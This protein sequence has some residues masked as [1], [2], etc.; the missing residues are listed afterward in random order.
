M[1]KIST[2]VMFWAAALLA[3]CGGGSS[4]DAFRPGAPAGAAP[5]ASVA[6]V[7]VT[8]NKVSILSDGSESATITAF[9]RDSGNALINGA[10]VTFGASSG[11]ISP[12]SATT[13]VDG[14]ATATLVT[15]GDQ[16]LR[17]ITV[18][19]TSGGISS[20]VAVPVVAAQPPVA[21]G[22]LTLSTSTPTIPSDGSNPATITAVVQDTSNRFLANVPVVFTTS[23]GGLAIAQSSTNTSGAATATLSTASD[24]T[25]RPITVTAVAGG[26]TRTVVVSVVGSRL[27][28]QGPA[29]LVLGAS[30][31]YT[32][33]LVDS[34]DR[35][36]AGR[37]ITATSAR[38]NTLSAPSLTTDATGR[39]TV[40]VTV[41]NAGN[42]TLTLTGLGL[43]TTQPIAV[44]SD[45]F[46]FTTPAEAAEIPLSTPQTVTIRW[47]TAGN[48]VAVGT[49]V[50]F[51]S[52]RGTVT[53]SPALTNASGDATVTIASTSAGAA[54]IVATGGGATAQ[55]SVE[56]VAST[57]ASID[58]Q[59]S[60]AT[61][62]ISEQ[63][64]ITAVVRDAA[65][66]LV[67]NKTVTFSLTD[68][69]GGT[70]SLASA[71]TNSQGRAQTVYTAGT[72]V[73]ARDGV[74]ITAS[75]PGAGGTP[76]TDTVNLTVARKEV[77]ISLGTGNTLE[78]PNAAQYKIT[79]VIQLTDANGNGVPNVPVTTSVLTDRYLKGFRVYLNGSW[80]NYGAPNY[81][82]Q[83]EDTLVPASA[84]NGQ[85]DP[86]ED[87]NNNGRLDVGNI[88]LVTPAQAT[89]NAQ[90]F[91]LV[92][93]LYPRDVSYWL[94]VTLEARAAVQ[95]T[96]FS[97][98]TSFRLPGLASDFN[99][100]GNA[101]PGP[102]S[103]FGV[104]ACGVAN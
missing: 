97:R 65:G 49:P 87:F 95:G 68:V 84:R 78:T 2:V 45:S 23:S 86:N 56:F 100:Q 1:R 57:A 25:N 44:N 20:T 12:P 98:S 4:D 60:T 53:G 42:D 104:N 26:I 72:S 43:T 6:T 88:A 91:V 22:S 61:V 36:I 50:T 64:T 75:V 93:V 30:A 5:T 94:D 17:T 10:T 33:S 51:T 46:T 37:A 11:G 40:T 92:D 21:V 27:S 89:T 54:S 47:L 38:G 71:V 70:L 63:S 55:R 39:A 31:Q 19:A 79:F 18:T 59:A 7:T 81:V 9:V 8:S 34:A 74:V 48:P 52:T 35:G 29:A 103:P 28:I 13:G 58:A 15:A 80:N 41:A 66:N 16:R 77:F 69:S 96:E 76:V 85:L 82:C 3:G 32:V 83:D 73:S 14:T 62:G 90:G 67:K 102:V 101:P 99:T 24:P